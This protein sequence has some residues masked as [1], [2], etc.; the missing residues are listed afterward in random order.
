MKLSLI[1]EVV[2]DMTKNLLVM[3][4]SSLFSILSFSNDE[5]FISVKLWLSA[6]ISQFSFFMELYFAKDL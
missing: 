2:F 3:E 6:V 1:G 4:L 5:V